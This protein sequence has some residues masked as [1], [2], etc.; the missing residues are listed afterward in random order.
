MSGVDGRRFLYV[1]S[2]G[3]PGTP[4]PLGPQPGR[5]LPWLSQPIRLR[6]LHKLPAAARIITVEPERRATCGAT[7][8]SP[9]SEC[10]ASTRSR[11]AAIAAGWQLLGASDGVWA[12]G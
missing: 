9:A 8:F 3:R 10:G 7:A 5:H 2:G 1:P 6:Y 4:L 12:S 11:A